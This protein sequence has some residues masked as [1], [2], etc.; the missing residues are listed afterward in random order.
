M[1]Q[2]SSSSRFPRW[3]RTATRIFVAGQLLKAVS[4]LTVGSP[5]A[6]AIA[7]VKVIRMVRNRRRV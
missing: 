7:L 2:I 5:V 6:R 4:R 1:I 3:A